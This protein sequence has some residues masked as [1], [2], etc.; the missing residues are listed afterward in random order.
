MITIYEQG[1]EDFSTMGMGQL[2]PTACVIHEEQGGAYELEL[3]HPMDEDGRYSLIMAGRVIRAPAPS[4]TTPLVTAGGLA[5]REIYTANEK[6]NLYSKATTSMGST[7]TVEVPAQYDTT[8]IRPGVV[9][10]QDAFSTTKWVPNGNRIVGT[11]STGAELIAVDKTNPSYYLVT[12]RLGV[13]GYVQASKVTYSKTESLEEQTIQARKTRDQPFRIY[14]I[15]KDTENLTVKA[16]ARHVYY[17]L[18]GNV[19]VA[20]AVDGDTIGD[21][22]NE[23]ALNCTQVDHGFR[24]GT[25]DTETLITADWSLKGMVE[26][27][28]DPD[29]GLASLGN[30]RVIRD[31]YD[32]FF[33]KRSTTARAPITYG[34]TLLGVRVD[35]NE[36]AVINRI[37]PVGKTSAGDPLLI[38]T[39]Y[40]DSPRND[41][42]T[43]I[44]AKVIEYDVKVGDDYPTEADAK[45]ELTARA[46]AD[47]E[48]GIDLPEVSVN[49]NMLQLG[50][51]E[52]YQQYKDLDRLYLGDLIRVIDNV[53]GVDV[54]A[55]INEYDFDCLA[56]RYTSLTIGVTDSM[57]LIGSVSGFMIPDG[58]VSRT[59]IVGGVGNADTLDGYHASD[60]SPAAH[61]HDSSYLKLTDVL[62]KTYPI[63]A[64][65]LAEESTS[66]GTLFG[67]TWASVTPPTGI[68]YAWKRT[69]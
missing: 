32:V 53:H 4:R 40:V 15:E 59:K 67:G 63:G 36:D 5:D 8:I 34:R 30:L 9:H 56:G 26:A 45:T 44:R 68:T 46:N 21:A 58:A 29:E 55:E 50:D 31:N 43:M 22:L 6:I 25:D 65:Y 27:Q 14:R 18:L 1:Y 69:A 17:D 7:V 35:I 39:V 64:V 61:N 48:A 66:P 54:E 24:F 28:L 10:L 23:M 16:W 37:V 11:V 47:F 20:C 19:L 3:E 12:T 60:F 38:D 52:E 49:V 41:A 2:F 42:A 33:V 57:R 51:T 13:T 62:S